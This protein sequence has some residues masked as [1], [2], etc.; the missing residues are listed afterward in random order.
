MKHTFC[1]VLGFVIW[2]TIFSQKQANVWHFGFGN[3]L[4]F[5]NGSP[6]TIS[7]SQIFAPEGCA[8][9]SDKCGNLLF[10]TNGG[11]REASCT[12]GS[13]DAGHI[14]NQI[15]GVMYDMQGTKGGGYSS[16]QSSVIFEV[17]GQD[18]L[19]YVFTMDELEYPSGACAATNSAQPKGRGLSY[20]IVNMHSN[21]GLG[22]ITTADQRVTVPS[23]EGLCAIRQSNK[24]DYW[25][26]VFDT[27]SVSLGVTAG[28]KVYSVTSTGV[29][30]S[31]TYSIPSDYH[32]FIKASPDGSKVATQ[33]TVFNF[34]NS[35]GQ[36]SNP[37]NIWGLDYSEFSPNSKY[38]YILSRNVFT[39]KNFY[40]IKYNLQ[41]NNR[42]TLG[43]PFKSIGQ[44]QLGPDGNI[45]FMTGADSPVIVNYLNRIN[46]P[47]TQN[48]TVDYQLYTYPY[49]GSA[50][51][52]NFSAW[53]FEN[54]NA[55]YVS[56]GADS[57][58]L[59]ET[60]CLLN[61]NAGNPG[62]TY[63]WSTGDTIQN[64]TVSNPGVYSVTVTGICGTGTDQVVVNSCNIAPLKLLTFNATNLKKDRS[65][66]LN[67]K[68]INEQ[69]LSHFDIQQSYNGKDFSTIGKVKSANNYTT[70][71]L[72]SY[73][74]NTA[75]INSNIAY[76]RLK[77][78]DKDGKFSYSNT[79]LVKAFLKSNS[80]IYPNPIFNK[81]IHLL[82]ENI[83]GINYIL[84]IFSLEGK[85]VLSRNIPKNFIQDVISLPSNIMAG[86]YILKV[87]S[88]DFGYVQQQLMVIN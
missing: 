45:Y 3:A 47:N 77:S 5:S 24:K 57:I 37:F 60:P 65:S 53:L 14:W 86:T 69:N 33:S 42:D 54:Y 16:T 87:R 78:I 48:P 63:L 59:C 41:N 32:Y 55:T 39:L 9:Y 20:F 8:S 46:C 73:I 19:Y 36:L 18:F 64:I 56:L 38:L 82:I 35:T 34:N 80:F 58:K 68:T 85:L 62:A 72:Y 2:M 66:K 84:E 30:Y 49:P 12:I 44:M 13:V 83:V 81:Q 23:A 74:D 88:E 25:I 79:E 43:P 4:N 21:G 40:L 11:G 29:N 26:L 67:W 61:L 31:A 10:Y 1:T 50:G 51:L 27:I 15:N 22:G 70:E 6:D 17:P 28:I 7:G 75:F 76:Y 71:N 52:P